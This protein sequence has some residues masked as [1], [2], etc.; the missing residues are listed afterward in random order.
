MYRLGNHEAAGVGVFYSFDPLARDDMIHAYISSFPIPLAGVKFLA[1]GFPHN[2][3]FPERLVINGPDMVRLTECKLA[4]KELFLSADISIPKYLFLNPTVDLDRII[5]FFASNTDGFVVKASTGSGG[6]YIRLFSS[7][8]LSIAENYVRDLWCAGRNVFLEERIHPLEIRD[9]AGSLVDWNIKSLMSFCSRGN[10]F[11]ITYLDS[12]I[13]YGIKGSLPINICRGGNPGELADFCALTSVSEKEIIE[14]AV[15]AAS[16]IC[17]KTYGSGFVGSPVPV[18][19]GLLSIDM[20]VDEI[21]V[22]V[23][24][25]NSGA[26]GGFSA[27][28]KLRKKKMHSSKLFLASLGPFLEYNSSLNQNLSKDW[29]PKLDNA[30]GY[31]EMGIAFSSLNNYP[32][33]MACFEN[34]VSLNPDFQEAY[35]NLG[36][37]QS[38]SKQYGA[39][40]NSFR[41]AVLLDHEFISAKHNLAIVLNYLGHEESSREEFM[42]AKALADELARTGDVVIGDLLK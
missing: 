35:N 21:G 41:K 6:K 2:H 37:L 11:D 18:K 4:T 15:A 8:E 3:G 22:H 7:D 23:L 1:E 12:L 19:G 36:I 26:V 32:A 14:T 13:R 5:S 9:S 30:V 40:L 29:I 25:A 28:A 33:A 42:D 16:V 27:L 34:S 10:D 17:R 24:E 39:A 38:R 31:F 20:M